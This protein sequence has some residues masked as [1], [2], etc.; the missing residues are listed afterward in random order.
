[1]TTAT[2]QARSLTPS[3]TVNDFKRSLRFYTEGLGFAGRGEG[4]AALATVLLVAAP[5]RA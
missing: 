3:L 1:M 2:L 5:Q 4:I